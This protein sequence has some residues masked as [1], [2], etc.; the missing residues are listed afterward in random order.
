[1]KVS[2]RFFGSLTETLGERRSVELTPRSTVTDLLA[3]VGLDENGIS[4]AVVNGVQVELA[5]ALNDGDQVMIVP[6]VIGG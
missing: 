1:M 4:L 2:V 6:P 5:H 3:A